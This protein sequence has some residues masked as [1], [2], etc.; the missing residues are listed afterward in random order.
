MNEEILAWLQGPRNYN[1]GVELYGRYGY[2]KILKKVYSTGATA[3]NTGSLVYE[4]AKL[5]GIQNQLD[6]MQRSASQPK[7]VAETKTTTEQKTT[8]T[9]VDDLLLQLADKFHV[10]VDD[11][12]SGQTVGDVLSADEQKAFDT[13]APKYQEIPETMKKIIRFRENYPFLKDTTCPDEL[14]VMVANMFAA[15]DRYRNAYALLSPENLDADNLSAAKEVVENY[16]DNKAMWA[17][18]D[19]YKENNTLLGE[20]PIFAELELKKEISGIADIDL[21]KK[22]GNASANITKNKNKYE[23]ATDDD[24]KAEYKTK[25]DHWTK[26]QTLIQAEIDSRTKK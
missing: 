13:L 11:L 7:P 24:K 23:A 1:E 6:T 10:H 21:S 18:L 2:N 19:H 9:Y 26:V 20:H 25:L 17:E 5:I 16:L 22:L 15:Y 3:S 8:V 12:F 14:K 4:L